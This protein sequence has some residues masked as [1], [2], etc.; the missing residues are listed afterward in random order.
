MKK[1]IV[2]NI[3]LNKKNKNRRNFNNLQHKTMIDVL[4]DPVKANKAASDCKDLWI[5]GTA[6]SYTSG[7]KD[8][9]KNYIP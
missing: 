3:Q 6:G 2:A 1:K 7:N 9:L 5:E 8:K 4:F